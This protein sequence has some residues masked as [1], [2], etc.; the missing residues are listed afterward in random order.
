MADMDSIPG[1]GRL[2]SLYSLLWS[3]Q[4][5]SAVRSALRNRACSQ[6]LGESR[7]VFDSKL[8]LLYSAHSRDIEQRPFLSIRKVMELT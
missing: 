5:N 4:T 2:Y 1:V 6:W 3:A 7:R 8:V